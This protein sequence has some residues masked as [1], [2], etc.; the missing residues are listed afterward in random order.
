MAI[1]AAEEGASAAEILPPNDVVPSSVDFKGRPSV[2]SKSGSW[3]SAF[4]IAGSYR[5]LQP[6]ARFKF[7]R[8]YF[9]EFLLQVLKWRRG[10]VIME[11]A[12]IL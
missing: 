5:K 6:Q 7:A 4:L 3:K 11:L 9:T 12:R 10:F 2:R 8:S 1:T